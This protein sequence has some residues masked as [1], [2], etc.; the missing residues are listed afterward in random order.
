MRIKKMKGGI[1]GLMMILTVVSA[2]LIVILMGS[3]G[4]TPIYYHTLPE[5]QFSELLSSFIHTETNLKRTIEEDSDRFFSNIQEESI[6]WNDSW[7]DYSDF[8]GLFSEKLGEAAND[9]FASNYV[10]EGAEVNASIINTS[11]SGSSLSYDDTNKNLTWNYIYRIYLSSRMFGEDVKN[12][13][14]TTRRIRTEF[15]FMDLG[16]VYS[17]ANKFF[18]TMGGTSYEFQKLNSDELKA[19]LTQKLNNVLEDKIECED[20]DFSLKIPI[21]CG[22]FDCDCRDMEDKPVTVTLILSQKGKGAIAFSEEFSD[23]VCGSLEN[24]C[25]KGAECGSGKDCVSGFCG[26]CLSSGSFCSPEGSTKSLSSREY[27][28]YK[29]KSE[30]KEYKCL[31]N[32]D[33]IEIILDDDLRSKKWE[34]IHL[35]CGEKHKTLEVYG[36]P[37]YFFEFNGVKIEKCDLDL[38]DLTKVP[39]VNGRLTIYAESSGYEYGLG[40]ININ[41]NLSRYI[42]RL[43]NKFKDFSYHFNKL[44]CD[45]FQNNVEEEINKIIKETVMEGYTWDITLDTKCTVNN[46]TTWNNEQYSRLKI[47]FIEDCPPNKLVATSQYIVKYK[48][49]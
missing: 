31:K 16:E 27:R 19:G 4:E 29:I 15:K 14:N 22:G 25:S 35:N 17:C 26:S 32:Y 40:G 2:G 6:P 30:E 10:L 43:N 7:V 20:F 48:P 44:D 49:S 8:I 38:C 42:E 46:P 3:V 13:I 36:V 34:K 23:F 47:E 5:I 41:F 12:E 18:K 33:N 1:Q 28:C 24:P 9:Y 21:S 45:E 11:G 39:R 37:D